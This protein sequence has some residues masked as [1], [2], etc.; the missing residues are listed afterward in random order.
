M[1]V[2][3]QLEELIMACLQ[4]KPEQRPAN[5]GEIR[6]ELAKFSLAASWTP[7]RAEKWWQTH[8]PEESAAGTEFDSVETVIQADARPH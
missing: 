5:A 2:P 6:K 8:M 4:K 3:P 7:E 1:E